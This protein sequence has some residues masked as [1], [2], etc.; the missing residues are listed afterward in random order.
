[1]SKP[2]PD[3]SKAEAREPATRRRITLGEGVAV[4][5]V[6]ISAM[7]LYLNWADKR[8]QRVRAAVEADR[9]SSRAAALVLNAERDGDD[10]LILSPD[11]PL[12]TIQSQTIR[13]PTQL[14][15]APVTT[16]GRPR[17]EMRWFKAGL[18]RARAKA[19]LPDNS[20]GDELLPVAITTRFV[21]E[22]KVHEDRAV[23]DIGYSVSGRMVAGHAMK[24]RGL[25]LIPALSHR[26]TQEAIDSRWTAVAVT[27]PH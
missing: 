26:P 17:I 11:A 3:S 13:F 6:L 5:A 8:D 22:G 1:M 25:S 21:V 4:L 24:L 27:M 18:I 19:G 14:G 20:V 2:A 9:Q 15:V 12:Q 10:R 7:T 16:T 23:Y